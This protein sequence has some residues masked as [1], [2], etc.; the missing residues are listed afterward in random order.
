MSREFVFQRRAVNLF[1]THPSEAARPRLARTVMTL[2]RWSGVQAATGC[3][4]HSPYR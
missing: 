4:W 1:R 3:C 2:L